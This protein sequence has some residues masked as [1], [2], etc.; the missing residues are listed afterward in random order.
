LLDKLVNLLLPTENRFLTYLQAIAKR[1]Q[2]GGD[3]FAELRTTTSLDEQTK[4]AERLKNI[5]HE[6]DGLAQLL[7]KELDRT[8][9]TPLDREDLHL[10]CSELDTVLD[11]AESCAN[12]IVIFRLGPLTEPMRELVRIYQ[13]SVRAIYRCVGL[14]SDLSKVEEIKVHVIHV[15]TLE[16]EGDSV[17]RGE[18]KRLFADPPPNMFELIRQV[19]VLEMLEHAID[20][21]EDVMDVIRSVAVKNG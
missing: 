12:R 15:N 7:Y 13:E 8:F 19:E 6:T 2:E 20:A 11:V 18:L 10:L 16:N 3:V 5:E 21:C 17:Y 9:V 4:I 14:L 1:V